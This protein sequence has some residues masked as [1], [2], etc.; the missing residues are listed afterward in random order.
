LTYSFGAL[1]QLPHDKKMTMKLPDCMFCRTPARVYL[2]HPSVGDFY[3]CASCGLIFQRGEDFLS[4]SEAMGTEDASTFQ[5][6]FS[7]KIDTSDA[8]GNMYAQFGIQHEE[9]VDGLFAD[10][11]AAIDRHAKGIVERSFNYL[12]VG[13]AT[14][15]MLDAA[16]RRY[17]LVQVFGVEP[18]PVSCAKAKELY[19]L[20]VHN[21]TLNTFDPGATRFDVISIIGN[22]QLHENPFDTL[23]RAHEL[24]VPGGLLIFHMKNPDSMARRIGRLATLLPVI[25]NK[26]ITRLICERGF[27]CMRYSAPKRFYPAKVAELGFELRELHTRPPR[28]L[29]FSDRNQGHAKGLMGIAWGAL[30]A[31]DSLLDQRAWIEACCTRPRA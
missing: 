26:G 5:K 19:Q 24:L 6:A 7:E 22:L 17:P 9:M 13:C 8:A 23:R 3:R 29:A 25:K 11:G 31:V 14:G 27:A 16:R 10:V 12:D 21:G 18:S 15:F 2:S 30:D 4:E 20:D 28:M 1:I